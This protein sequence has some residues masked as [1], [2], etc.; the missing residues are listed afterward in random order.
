MPRFSLLSLC[1]VM[2]FAGWAPSHAADR[3]KTLSGTTLGLLGAESATQF[4]EALAA[5]EEVVW[6]T[7][8][9]KRYDPAKPAGL[10]VYISPSRS[11]RIPKGWK[12]AM[13][14]KNLI[15]MGANQSGNTVNT[16]RRLLMAIMAQAKAKAVFAID[17]TRIYL[18]GF[19]GGGRVASY[20]TSLFPE[21]FTGG[22]YI[23]GVEYKTLSEPKRAFHNRPHV[24]ITGR[25]DFNRDETRQRHQDMQA[26]GVE[27]LLLLDIRNLGHSVP[28]SRHL[29]EAIRFLDEAQP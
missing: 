9:P 13:D 8:V 2:A 10:L 6:Q 17:P 29:A 23:C 15:Y 25:G 14:T 4:Q 16:P 7:Y 24:L 18:S 12:P 20:V 26:G 19:S 1:L 5:D 22:I 3:P 21:V 11:G 28:K 27:S